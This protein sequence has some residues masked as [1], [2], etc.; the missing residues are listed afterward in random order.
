LL[1]TRSRGAGQWSKNIEKLPAAGG[2][3]KDHRLTSRTLSFGFAVAAL[4]IGPFGL[5]AQTTPQSDVKLIQPQLTAPGSLPFHLKSVIY[6]KDDPDNKT[7]VE[8]FWAAP[9]RWRRT[10]E[11]DAFTQTIIVNSDK[12]FEKVSEDYLPLHLET[13]ILAMVDPEP[14]LKSLRPGDRVETQANGGRKIPPICAKLRP[15]DEGRFAGLCGLGP[16]KEMETIGAPGHTVMFADYQKFKDS[17]VARLL[18]TI[19]ES[20][21]T[22]RADVSKLEELKHPDADLFAVADPTPKDKQLSTAFLTESELRALAVQKPEIIW[23]QVLDGK[24]EG[25][26]SYFVSVD[27][28]GTVRETVVV[29]SDNERANDSARRQ[30]QKWRFTPAS[31]DGVP[32]QAEGILTFDLN[33]RAFGPANPLTNDEA[34]RLASNVVEPQ[35]PGGKFPSGTVY[36]LRVAVDNEG[37]VIE[38]IAGDGPHE[39]FSP[40]YDALKKWKFGPLMENGQP[41]PYRANI[42]FQVPAVN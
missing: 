41:R 2:L 38:V 8:I 4:T 1:E 39:L 23:P 29:N 18:I 11:S 26:A 24:T 31:K 7:N 22:W 37:N 20:G 27:R 16:F 36:S 40:C 42:S 32:V 3:R 14:L 12:T 30:L 5:T 28:T 17:K 9:D 25:T 13:L 33:T 34:R 15:G 35:I 6:E 21:V 19:P 10:I